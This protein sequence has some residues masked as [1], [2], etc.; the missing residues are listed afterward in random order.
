MNAVEAQLLTRL[1]TSPSEEPLSVS[2][3]TPW[4]NGA[5]LPLLAIILTAESGAGRT[6]SM[7]ALTLPPTRDARAQRQ[8]VLQD[9]R[10]EL[11]EP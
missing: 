11:G 2:A 10:A 9:G 3:R 7:N 6:R 5:T 8:V 1:G 4:S